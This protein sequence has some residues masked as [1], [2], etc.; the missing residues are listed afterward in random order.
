MPTRGQFLALVFLVT[1]AGAET[2]SAPAQ[3]DRASLKDFESIGKALSSSD[4]R[5]VHI[6]Y[7]HGINQVGAGD[8]ETLRNAICDKLHLCDKSDWKYAGSDFADKGEFAPDM[9]PPKLEFLG[10]NIWAS[11]SEW[12][13]S[14]P[15]V[16]H[17]VIG[18][19]GYASPLVVDE[20]NWWPL[21]LALKCQYVVKSEAS[22]AGPNKGLLQVCSRKSSQDPDNIGRFHAWLL[23]EEADQLAKMPAHAVLINRD[24][25][26]GLEDWGFSDALIG[27]GPL[28]RIIRDGLRQLMFKSASFGPNGA[29]DSA[30]M[31]YDW[32]SRL[33]SGSATDQ[34]FIGVTHSLGSYLLFNTFNLENPPLQAAAEIS[35]PAESLQS[36]QAQEDGAIQYIFERMPIIYFFANQLLLLEFTNLE[37]TP[38]SGEA[39]APAG[40]APSARR[41]NA[42]VSRWGQYRQGL[43]RR[44]NVSGAP[45]VSSEIVAWSDP[46]DLLTWLVPQ[47]N[48]VQ[49][50]NLQV[51]NAIHWF[52]LFE[53]PLGAHDNYAKN[54][55]VL[56]VMFAKQ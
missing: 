22:L 40:A 30:R 8:S 46:G 14:A 32:K 23:P 17:Y 18:L 45:P 31:T 37:F 2:K 52:W 26:N 55:A 3:N 9:D 5:P 16:A 15:F 1:F 47:V 20:I 53:S 56:R 54:K 29:G 36:E 39:A 44:S 34:T 19:H 25:K 28:A 48:D 33:A 42:L 51:R 35:Q 4:H 12:Q 7:V 21:V 10:K 41:F 50:V 11:R 49:V 38:I 13:D 24:L 43:Q 6:I 27:V